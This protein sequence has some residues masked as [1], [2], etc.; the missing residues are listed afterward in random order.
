MYSSFMVIHL[1]CT[2]LGLIWLPSIFSSV[3]VL[4]LPDHQLPSQCSLCLF[5]LQCCFFLYMTLLSLLLTSTLSFSSHVTWPS[6]YLTALF[7]WDLP[8][9][10]SVQPY[11]DKKLSFWMMFKPKII[12][13]PVI[14]LF[15]QW[16]D[17]NWK[18]QWV[19]E[20][21]LFCLLWAICSWLCCQISYECVYYKNKH[22]DKCFIYN[23]HH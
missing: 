3:K 5:Y 22:F 7:Q 4:L 21:H 15:K 11:F 19:Q 20:Q 23:F 13:L 2:Y 16:T 6:T 9:S 8:V 1:R 12:Y 14:P 17:W 18:S 10:L